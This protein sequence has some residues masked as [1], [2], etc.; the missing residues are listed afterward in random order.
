MKNEKPGGH[1]ERSVAV[2]VHRHGG[3]GR[4]GEDRARAA[5]PVA[6]RSIREWRGRRQGL[7]LR[8]RRLLLS[9]KDLA[10]LQ[11]EM[12]GYLD[13]GYSSRQDQDWRRAAGGGS[14]ADRGGAALLDR[15]G[16][17]AVDA[18]GRFDLAQAIEYGRALEP[19]GLLW[20]E[21]AGDPLDYALQAELS[22]TMQARWPPAR[23]C[24]RCWMPAIS[25]DTA[26]CVPT[27]TSCSSIAR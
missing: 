24:S 13:Q 26:G 8:R 5:V 3:V 15:P 1:G 25:S 22:K 2:G 18:N 6:G 20:Y 12:Q 19:Y 21:E 4:R 17:L 9:G 11:E 7:G 23:I 27:A 16:Q 14:E 10:A